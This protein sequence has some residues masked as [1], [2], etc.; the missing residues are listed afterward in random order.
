MPSSLA[1]IATSV[2]PSGERAA[3]APVTSGALEASIGMIGRPTSSPI[4]ASASSPANAAPAAATVEPASMAA[5]RTAASGTSATWATA[6][7]VTASSA[8]WRRLPVTMAC[9]HACSAAVARPKSAVT[10]SLRASCDPGPASRD[11]ASKASCTSS[12]V[13]D[14]SSAGEGR[15]LTPRQPRPVRRWRSAPPR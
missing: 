1:S 6:S 13:S 10:A 3:I 9:S 14:G 12:T 2:A 11:I 4:S 15:S 7:W 5:R 8:P